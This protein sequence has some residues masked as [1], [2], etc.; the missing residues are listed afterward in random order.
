VYWDT[1]LSVGLRANAFLSAEF[2][3]GNGP[4]NA[5]PDV[6]VIAQSI[7]PERLN[8]TSRVCARRRSE[9]NVYTA[10]RLSG[11]KPPPSSLVS[12]GSLPCGGTTADLPTATD[13]ATRA[14]NEAS[15][16]QAAKPAPVDPVLRCYPRDMPLDRAIPVPLYSCA[17]ASLQPSTLRQN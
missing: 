1:L 14:R 16:A 10:D 2:S 13:E 12:S 7:D 4:R 9:Y 15:A 8:M 6:P 5:V 17:V 3:P 11:V